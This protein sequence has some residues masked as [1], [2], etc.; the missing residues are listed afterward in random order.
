VSARDKAAQR[1]VPDGMRW[2]TAN[3]EQTAALMRESFLKGWDAALAE[4]TDAEI[5]SCAQ[6]LWED[7]GGSIPWDNVHPE[8]AGYQVDNARIVLTAFL[9]S[10]LVQ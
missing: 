3:P 5:E 9:K 2:L 6:A 8:D 4:P 10:R 1:Y 7:H